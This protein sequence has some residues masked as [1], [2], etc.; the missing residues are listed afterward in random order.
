MAFWGTI[1][2]AYEIYWRTVYECLRPVSQRVRRMSTKTV[3]WYVL[4]Y[5]GLAG[6]ALTW[7]TENPVALITFPSLVGGVL[8]CGLWCFGM[9]WLDRTLLPKPLQMKTPLLVA[10][11]VSGTLLAGIG[12]K[13]FFDFVASLV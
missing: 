13:A 5:C 9:V 11:L 12:G 10:T 3:R 8:T 6:I 7:L 4:V 2:G 1:Y